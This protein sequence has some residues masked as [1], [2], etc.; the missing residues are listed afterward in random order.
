MSSE[1]TNAHPALAEFWHPVAASCDVG[2]E[3]VA[4][5]LAGQGWALARLGGAVA[6]FADGL[7]PPS[8]FV[9]PPAQSPGA[10]GAIEA[11]A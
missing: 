10:R 1:F 5:R 3:P 11:H 8:L 7:L 6:A 4:V 2:E 9:L